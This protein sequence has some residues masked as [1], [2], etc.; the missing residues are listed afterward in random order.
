MFL[1]KKR[2]ASEKVDITTTE[3]FTALYKKYVRYVYVL[4][5]HYLEDKNECQDIASKIFT[6]IWERRNKLDNE[7]SWKHYLRQATKHKVYDYLKS[8][9]R[10][11]RHLTTAVREFCSFDDSTENELSLSELKQQIN[12][13]VDQL[14]PKC[15]EVFMLSREKGMSN[16]EIASH[17]LIS[18]NTVKTHLAKALNYLRDR[19]TDYIV[20][21]RGTGT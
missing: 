21:K 14:P 1:S 7:G 3:G 17:L 2:R 8:Q 19:L 4:C 10:V 6:S 9:E 18:D 13:L 16:K 11:D 5:R 20:P 12:L 15:K